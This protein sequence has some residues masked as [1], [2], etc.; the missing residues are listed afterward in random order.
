MSI[1]SSHRLL[2]DWNPR[3]GAC[4]CVDLHSHHVTHVTS[5]P[6]WATVPISLW[7]DL[8]PCSIHPCSISFPF[9][10]PLLYVCPS[11]PC[12]SRSRSLCL[13][14]RESPPNACFAQGVLSA[15]AHVCLLTTSWPYTTLLGTALF[16]PV[17]ELIK[18]DWCFSIKA[19][20]LCSCFLSLLTDWNVARKT[21]FLILSVPIK[22]SEADLLWQHSQHFPPVSLL[23]SV[24]C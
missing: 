12:P 9:L 13:K 1:L 3:P 5:W 8:N 24:W 4:S 20:S 17:L 16:P 11:P 18:W 21:F 7:S 10:P 22:M 15:P 6:S 14:P 23:H 19:C 2:P